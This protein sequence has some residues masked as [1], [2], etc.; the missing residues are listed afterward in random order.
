MEHKII[1]V[2]IGPGS[3]DYIL[4]VASRI[5]AD[6]KVIAGSKR[7]LAT[8]APDHAITKVI[9]N[10][11]KGV[12]TFIAAFL[13]DNDVVVMVSGDPGFYSFLATL[14]TKFSPAQITVIPGIS[15][16]QLAFARITE[17]WQDAVLISMHGRQ[18]K[19]IDLNYGPE[20]KLG[21]LT[22]FEQNPLYIANVLLEHGWPLHSKVWLC[23]NLSYENEKIKHLTLGEIKEVD[24][25]AHCVMVV[26]I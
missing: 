7:A 3:P 11:L 9:D 26:T 8:F 17:I 18:A 16:M 4:P 12:L 21:I 2:G 10:D 22:D 19:D 1:V 20:K 23:A 5:I 6:A 24:G 15:S 25:F 13:M 14:K